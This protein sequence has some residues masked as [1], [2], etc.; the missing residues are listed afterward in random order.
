MASAGR[1]RIRG[2]TARRRVITGSP[3]HRNLPRRSVGLPGAW[4]VLLLRAVVVH[5]AGCCLPSPDT[6]KPPSPSRNPNRSAPRMNIVFVAA[7]PRPTR[8]RDYASPDTLPRPSQV[9]LPAGRARPFAGRVSHPQDDKPNFMSSSHLTPFGPAVP[10][11]TGLRY[12]LRRVDC[13]RCGVIVELVPWAE[14]QSWFTYE[15]EQHVAY[16]AQ[17]TDKTTLS[18]LMRIAWPTVG[19]SSNASCRA[20]A[21]PTRSKDCAHIGVDELSYRRHHEYVTVVIDHERGAVVWARE[22]KDAATLAAFFEELGKERCAKARGGHARPVG[23][24]H[25]G[26]D[27]SLAA[28]SAHLRPLPRAAARPRCA[29]HRPPPAVANGRLRGERGHQGNTL[30]VAEESVESHRRR[31]R[32]AHRRAADQPASLPRPTCSRRHSP[33]SSTAP[34]STSRATSCSIGSHGQTARNCAPFR[35]V[36]RTI[37]KHIEGIVAYVAT[38][39]SSGRSEGLNG[40]IRTITRRSFGFHSATSLIALI[41]LCCGGINLLPVHK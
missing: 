39:L 36:A 22:G 13:P 2:R 18:L 4:T 23:G 31:A 19:A 27:R 20:T 34:R 29:R 28:G 3:S 17:K 1:A 40:K 6:G 12:S 25:Q 21:R 10:G 8:S 5:P 41:T 35:K 11:R 14:S 30:R 38:G 33:R 37:K 7:Y 15:F 24:L 26:G 32:K 16:L 9:S